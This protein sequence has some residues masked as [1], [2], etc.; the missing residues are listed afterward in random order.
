[1]TD[2]SQEIAST[3]APLA[4]HPLDPLTPQEISAAVQIVRDALPARNLSQRTRFITIGL[5][6]PP[7]DLVLAF[8]EGDPIRREAEIILLDNS[9]G[10]TYEVVVSLTESQI[11][12]WRHV[13]GVQPPT[14]FDEIMECGPLVKAHQDFRAALLRRGITD[15]GLAMIDAWTTGYYGPED[16]PTRR[17]ARA[18]VFIKNSPDDNGYAHPVEGLVVMIDLNKMEVVRVEDYGAVPI[19]A[20]SGNYGVEAAGPM[21]ADLKP[22]EIL[23]PEGPSFSVRGHEVRWQKWR[24]RLGWSPREGLVLHTIG[25]EDQGRIRPILYRA[26]VAEML[27]PYGDPRPAHYHKNVFDVGE[28]GLGGTANALELG[29]DCL[30]HIQYFDAVD[31]NTRGEV[32]ILPN[33]ICMHEEDYGLLWKH[34][35]W[36]TGEVEVRRSRRLVISFIATVG[37]YDYGFYWYFYQDGSLQLEIKLTGVMHAGAVAP[38]ETPTHGVLVAPGVNALIHQH[39]F[40]VRLDMMIDGLPNA[41]YEVHTEAEPPGPQNPQG[42]A[43]SARSTLLTT[44]AEAQQVIDPLAGRYW[45][46]VNPTVRNGLGEPVA[47]KLMPGENILPFFHPESP[48]SKRGGFARKHLWV[49]PYAASERF[50]AGDYPNQHPGGAGLPDWT[51]AN[52]SIENTNVVLWYTMGAH[53]VPRPEDWPVMP[54]STVSFSLKP[55]GFFDRNPALDVPPPAPKHDACCDTTG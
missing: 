50:P 5:H 51:R 25:Y 27:V 22:I 41:V 20:Q 1:M 16:A 29:C 12:Q 38:G 14:A 4:L 48:A 11:M 15:P 42:N 17:L 9:D 30:G 44:E 19:P 54:V 24:L 8:Q 49:T 53:H 23:Q 34:T 28:V 33:A 52:R 21:R 37:H 55:L 7:K 47:Y 45:K 26:S 18:Y 10:A 13:P 36:R 3:D 2:L 6:E 40:S 43:F 31:T 32:R 35:D 39:F 46:I